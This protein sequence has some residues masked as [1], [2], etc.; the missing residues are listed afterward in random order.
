MSQLMSSRGK[1][2]ARQPGVWKQVEMNLMGLFT[3]R[4]DVNLE[5]RTKEAKAVLE[6]VNM[7]VKG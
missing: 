1:E 7:K 5:M 3:C 4:S 2:F 6:N